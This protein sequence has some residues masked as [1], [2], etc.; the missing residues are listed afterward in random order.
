MTTYFPKNHRHAE[1]ESRIISGLS[2]TWNAIAPD[3]GSV[4]RRDL[5]GFLLD[6]Y[7]EMYG[8][9]DKEDLA[10]WNELCGAPVGWKD[11]RLAVKISKMVVS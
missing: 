9:L 5:H 8:G 7:V 10:A 6:C 11:Y 4:P 1:R 3:T 2:R